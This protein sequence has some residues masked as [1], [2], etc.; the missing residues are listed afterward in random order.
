MLTTLWEMAFETE[1]AVPAVLYTSPSKQDAVGRNWEAVRLIED[2]QLHFKGQSISGA[3][4]FNINGHDVVYDMDVCDCWDFRK[5]APRDETH[6]L[7]KH[8]LAAR[9]WIQTRVQIRADLEKIIVMAE[10]MGLDS[11]TFESRVYFAHNDRAHGGVQ[12]NE[13]VMYRM[14][15]LPA[16]ELSE[17]LRFYNSDLHEALFALGWMVES[18]PVGG[19]DYG[20]RERWVLA[21]APTN[22]E[23]MLPTD[24]TRIWRLDSNSAES[25]E[26]QV[27]ERKLSDMFNEQ[28]DVAQQEELFYA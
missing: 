2:G 23:Q 5:G 18:R 4:M 28:M 22:E 26:R 16:N 27:R 9:Y 19:T 14:G 6:R 24:K 7:C 12:E 3:H 15:K 10:R 17:P 20:G 21:P 25:R 13:L 11:V 1:A 8:M